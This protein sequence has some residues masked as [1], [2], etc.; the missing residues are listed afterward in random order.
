MNA[1]VLGAG[2]FGT[3]LAAVLGQSCERVVLW[4]R[5]AEVVSSINERHENSAYL[6]SLVLP[7]NVSATHDVAEATAGSSLVVCAVPA[8]ATREVM[9]F[10]AAHLPQHVPIVS[11]GKGIENGTLMTMTQ[12][13]EDALPEQHHPYLAVLSGPSFARE[14]VLRLPTVVTI[15]AVWPRVAQECQRAF[16]SEWF[17]TYTSQDVV[18][19]QIGGALKNV[20]AIA[21]GLSDGLGLGHNARAGIITRGLAEMTRM[22]VALGGNPLTLS[23]LA[24]LGDLVLTCTAEMSRNRTIG[25]ELGRGRALAEVLADGRGV[26]EGVKTAESAKDLAERTRVELPICAQVYAITHLGKSPRAAAEELMSRAPKHEL[27]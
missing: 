8:Q 7:P 3:A 5:E 16:H 2:S 27:V 19:V 11:V 10:A 24:G 20:V 14:M 12:V 26:V 22:A 9:R 15:A 18:G 21:A 17:R 6:P 25:F 4:G 1:C 23:G 13:M